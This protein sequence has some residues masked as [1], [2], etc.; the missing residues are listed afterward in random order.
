MASQSQVEKL[1]EQIRQMLADNRRLALKHLMTR[2]HFADL[3]EVLETRLTEEEANQCLAV[4]PLGKAAE[5]LNSLNAD[6]QI[7]GVLS[8]P[9]ARASRVLRLMGAD[10]AVDILQ[11]LP[12]DA[13]R[14]IL[15]EMP[16]DDDTHSLHQLLLEEPDT[17]AGIMA[18][19]FIQVSVEQTVGEALES[20]RQ[21]D[22]RDF[23]Y[24]TYLV[25][26]QERLVGVVSLKTLILKS[27]ETPLQQVAN[28]DIKTVHHQAD[29]S[30]VVQRF[31]KYHNLLAMPV[32]D[33]E[34]YILGIVTLD[35]V[36]DV[37]EEE[38]VEDI[39][40]ASGITLDDQD[41]KHLLSGPVWKAV[42]SRLPWLSITMVGQMVGSLIITGFHDTVEKAAIAIS[43]MPLLSGL[44]GNIGSQ[45]DVVTV[46]GL[47]LS[48]IR[49]DNFTSKLL[50][51]LRVAL[52]ISAICAVIVGSV[53]YIWYHKPWFSLL[54]VASILLSL[55]ISAL[56][57]M[58]IPFWIRQTF[59]YDPA[60]VGAPFLTTFMD[61][62]TFTI[63]LALLS[64]LKDKIF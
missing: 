20:V 18:T 6:R 49:P 34:E 56:L 24:Y 46:R 23:I 44:S 9:H 55:C 60:G 12:M 19:E 29:Q 45:T 1:T 4:M 26:K 41:E 22:E 40:Q 25:D 2:L 33:E 64:V 61:I 38:T 50:R 48:Q 16:T 42:R 21:A 51:E 8:M 15:G 53:S 47:A 39:Y 30:E 31:R 10:D 3:T 17:A 62:L 59:K 63:Y 28:F 32:V 27:P 58:V 13:R 5:V 11:S 52:A 7:A 36:L 35:D 43:F 14:R 37:L 54:L 57:G